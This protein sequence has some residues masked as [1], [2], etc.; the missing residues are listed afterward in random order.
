M[1]DYPEDL[2][3][4]TEHE[5]VRSGNGSRVRVG[6][7]EYAAD[8]LGDIVFVSLPEVGDPVSAGDACGELESTKSVS[9]IFC[10]VPGVIT[11]VNPLLEANPEIIN[12]D[13]YG[14]GWLFE[15][16]LDEGADLD[17]LL[18]ADSYAEQVGG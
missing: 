5:W 10:P 6:I 16:D 12:A 18:D 2:K 1:S 14:D 13:P 3:Y 7:T 8:Q 17:D 11:T 9:D 15:L 4:S